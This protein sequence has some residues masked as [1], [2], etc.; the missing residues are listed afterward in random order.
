MRTTITI[1]DGLLSQVKEIA[2]RS[3]RTVSSVLED[4]VRETLARRDGTRPNRVRIPVSGSVDSK[5]L[6]DIIDREALA[7]VLDDDRL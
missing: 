7:V 5:P 2:A 6:V 1:D 3:N 4:A